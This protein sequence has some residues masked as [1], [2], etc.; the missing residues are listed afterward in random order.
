MDYKKIRP[1]R[2]MTPAALAGVAVLVVASGCAS[3]P[4]SGS[5]AQAAASG[6]TSQ[7]TAS[8]PAGTFAGKQATGTPVKVGLINDEGGASV[9]EPTAREAAQAVVTYANA[10]LGGIGGHPID[11]IICKE[12][13]DPASAATCA[14]QMVADNVAAVVVTETALGDVMA[15]IIQ[16]A[17]IPYVSYLGASTAEL[18][19]KDYS[20]AWTSGFQGLLAGMAKYAARHGFKTFTLF[21]Q[22]VAAVTVGAQSIGGPA[23]KSAGVALKIEN[24][25]A[26]TPDATPQVAAGLKSSPGAIGIIGDDTVC[27]SVLDALSTLGSSVPRLANQSCTDPSVFKAAG[28]TLNGTEI[29]SAADSVGNDPQSETYR[30]VMAKYAPGVPLSG[31]SLAGYQ[32]MY[33]FI[34]ATAKA[35]GTI[36]A[37]SLNQAIRAAKD[38][39]VPLGDGG[40]MT[41]DGQAV[42]AL[43]MICNDSVILETVDGSNLTDPQ[44]VK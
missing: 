43:P 18:T 5:G 40:T 1:L 6:G 25:P 12:Q 39:P 27:I 38:V 21:A 35:A 10:D 41:C 32:S 28:G 7:A 4:S 3:S 17:K 2:R 36:S 22:D 20:Y 31:P 23:F 37:A 26:T 33:G 29:V 11:L 15:P 44:L 16:K 9:S 30:A 13:E 24:I 14:N 19:A 42:P 8:A 34:L